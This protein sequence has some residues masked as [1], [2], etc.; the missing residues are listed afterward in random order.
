[1]ITDVRINTAVYCVL[2]NTDNVDVPATLIIEEMDSVLLG[3]CVNNLYNIKTAVKLVST[4]T[5]VS[6]FTKVSGKMC[7]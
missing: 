5:V 2:K 1:M 3:K 4:M 6:E 7:L